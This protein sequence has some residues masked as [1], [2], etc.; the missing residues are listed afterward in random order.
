M[1]AHDTYVRR[2][3]L[4]HTGADALRVR[5]RLRRGV[6][7]MDLRPA[8]LPPSAILLVRSLDDA[9]PFDARR[10]NWAGLRAWERTL[11]RRLD[12]LFRQAVRP[13]GGRIPPGA[14]A[15]LFWDDAETRA[16][17]TVACALS[18][19]TPGVPAWWVSAATSTLSL[20]ET[21]TPTAILTSDPAAAPAVW[22]VLHAWGRDR[23][24]AATLSTA[25]A[26]MIL[27]KTCAAFGV[28][29]SPVDTAKADVSLVPRP[30]PTRSTFLD[31]LSP[32]ECCRRVSLQMYESPS[33]VQFREL[34][35]DS[36]RV[37]ENDVFFPITDSGFNLDDPESN[38]AE[39][40][41]LDGDSEAE[42]QALQ[43]STSQVAPTDVSSHQA[44]DVAPDSEELWTDSE[45]T[46]PE[47]SE[48]SSDL[49]RG[50]SLQE[51]T[52][53]PTP[54]SPA[55]AVDPV[56]EKGRPDA[57]SPTVFPSDQDLEKESVEKT[58]RAAPSPSS[59][60]DSSFSDPHV[61]ENT[62]QART[63]PSPAYTTL[64]GLFYLANVTE[65]LGLPASF[66][67]P[68]L[69]VGAWAVVESLARVLLDENTSGKDWASDPVWR[70]LAML[71]ARDPDTR[72]GHAS[73]M[74]EATFCLPTDWLRETWA[75]ASV[76]DKPGTWAVQEER[77]RLWAGGVLVADVPASG[78]PDEQ[79]DEIW[80]RTVRESGS[81]RPAPDAADVVP[82]DDVLDDD[83]PGLTP[84]L[85]AWARR[86]APFVR[87]RLQ[88][89]LVGASADP[90]D[91]TELLFVDAT[92]HV[93]PVHVDVVFPL[94]AAR[95]DVRCAGLD[96]DPGWCPAFSRVIRFHFRS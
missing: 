43:P 87:A 82:G 1:P 37:F 14:V 26:E 84:G 36:E 25:D 55:D 88:S 18:T 15:V 22:S 44:A 53:L 7:A 81:L 46:T 33:G 29:P 6:E 74:S 32:Q 31:A 68:P 39:G 42:V 16:A 71:D 12:I 91:V 92:V 21:P 23:E 61:E 3:R 95:L 8:G 79:A 70:V 76:L 51:D 75:Q 63:L 83:V 89:A 11:R 85:S 62:S 10:L 52:S 77:L 27:Q 20:P 50:S 30:A 69:D 47:L 78:A 64:G 65:A 24:V 9:T 13:V 57:A 58:D 67:Q 96:R 38:V 34:F 56:S 49:E 80:A 93:A 59:T 48:Q 45:V 66:R 35:R 28:D 41:D 72:A 90:F 5:V 4:R 60:A 54:S 2:L 73:T 86:V 17:L 94:D 40:F 19:S